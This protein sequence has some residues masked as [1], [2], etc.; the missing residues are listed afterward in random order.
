[1]SVFVYGH[2]ASKLYPFSSTRKTGRSQVSHGYILL[3]PRL[4]FMFISPSMVPTPKVAPSKRWICDHSLAG[5]TGSD[6]TGAWMSVFCE[7]CRVCRV[8]F[9]G[10]TTRPN[11]SYRVWCVWVGSWCPGPLGA[12]APWKKKF[13]VNENNSTTVYKFYLVSLNHVTFVF[14]AVY[15]HV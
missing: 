1:M 6:P 11:E 8:F 7:C 13:A 5:I 3:R 9:I 10:L 15:Q 12:V 14:N 2:S 4:L